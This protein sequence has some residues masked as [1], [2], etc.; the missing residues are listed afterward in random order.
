MNDVIVR[1]AVIGDLLPIAHLW[2]EL[3][4]FHFARDPYFEVKKDVE[5]VFTEFV[6]GNI[7]SERGVVFVAEIEGEVVGFCHGTVAHY[8]PVHLIAEY[9][10]VYDVAVTERF[11]RRGIGAL[12]FQSIKT[13]FQAK[14]LRRLE[15]H[16]AV[17]NEVSMRF[18]A[19][20]GLRSVL[21]TKYLD[22]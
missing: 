22:L 5:S 8:P 19:K 3:M 10:M 15:L 2:K 4:E 21:E 7:L 18:W 13:W 14:G 11:R 12:L 9:G 16:V 17:N 20:M 1:E 6:K